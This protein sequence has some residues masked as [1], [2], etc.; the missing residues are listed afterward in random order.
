M[1]ITSG[2]GKRN[3][4]I[5]ISFINGTTISFGKTQIEDMIILTILRTAPLKIH[6]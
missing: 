6:K 2:S 3:F 5:S 1:L 4:T